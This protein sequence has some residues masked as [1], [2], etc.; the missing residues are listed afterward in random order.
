MIA[1][2]GIERPRNYRPDIDGLRALAIVLVVLSHAGLLFRGGFLGVDIFFVISGYLITGLV[3]RE[4]DEKRFSLARFWMRRIHRLLPALTVA[5]LGTIL[6]GLIVLPPKEL[7]ELGRSV[8]A[9]SVLL[10]NAFFW[11]LSGYFDGAATQKPLLHYWSLAVEE[12]FYLL[13]PFLLFLRPKRR[14]LIALAMVSFG[15]LL[16]V[17]AYDVSA[18]FYLLAFRAWELILGGV[19]AVSHYEVGPKYRVSVSWVGL[20]AILGAAL[21]MSERKVIWP[22]WWTWIPCLG[23]CLLIASC[24]SAQTPVARWLSHPRVVRMGIVSYSWYLWHWPMIAFWNVWKLGHTPLGVRLTWVVLSYG[25]A[26]LSYTYIETP[27]RRPRKGWSA[28]Q[29]IAL[30]LG[31]QAGMACLGGALVLGAGFPE[32][33]PSRAQPLVAQGAPPWDRFQVTLPQAQKGEFLTLG[34]EGPVR[35]WLWGDSHAMAI[36]SAVEEL[37]IKERCRVIM[38]THSGVVPLLGYP[39]P[40][41]CPLG[42][43][44]Q[45]WNQAVIEHLNAQVP[46]PKVLMVCRFSYKP[47]PELSQALIETRRALHLPVVALLKEVPVYPFDLNKALLRAAWWGGSSE[48]LGLTLEDYRAQNALDSR[49]LKGYQVLNPELSFGMHEGRATVEVN[50]LSCYWDDNHLSAVGAKLLEPLL[51]PLLATP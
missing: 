10:S 25:L 46:T 42:Q 45:A 26:V 28:Y 51:R 23:T 18:G 14:T 47:Q 29:V 24:R 21:F 3:E 37:A 8:V 31:V 22:G 40:D 30:G 6:L 36:A 49:A 50:G 32:R 20:G 1:L 12:Q 4:L 13:Y 41:V 34:K 27:W 17:H 19:L 11:Q 15:G 35:L 7:M 48:R 2:A 44:M 5:S 43:K 39:A 9:Q 16:A 38:A 33:L